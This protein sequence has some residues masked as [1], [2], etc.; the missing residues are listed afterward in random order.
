MGILEER[1]GKL[2]RW[3]WFNYVWRKKSKESLWWRDLITL[4]E[5]DESNRL[6]QLLLFLLGDGYSIPFWNAQWLGQIPLASLFPLIFML[7]ADKNSSVVEQ[8]GW[9]NG[10]WH[11][12]L[13]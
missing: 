8:G 5:D 9:L 12:S 10:S 3:W 4:K 7:V 13:N 11:L 1:Y 6:R 2:D